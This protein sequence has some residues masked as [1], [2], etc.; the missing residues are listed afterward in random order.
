MKKT[1]RIT[2]SVSHVLDYV[3][4]RQIGTTTAS[5]EKNLTYLCHNG[6]EW[7]GTVTAEELNECP[8]RWNWH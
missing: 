4:S 5:V 2:L 6:I 3:Y 8:K 7:Q 1:N